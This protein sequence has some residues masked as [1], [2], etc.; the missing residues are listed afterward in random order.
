MG[1][2]NTLS[3]IYY[4]P[5]RCAYIKSNGGGEEEHDYTH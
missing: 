1:V 3:I 5:T 2:V 4:V